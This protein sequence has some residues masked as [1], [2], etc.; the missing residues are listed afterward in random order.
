MNVVSRGD[1]G[2]RLRPHSKAHGIYQRPNLVAR[3][4]YFAHFGL[5]TLSF[6]SGSGVISSSSV[7]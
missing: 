2:M 4:K 6:V 1:L 5:K 7:F 3:D